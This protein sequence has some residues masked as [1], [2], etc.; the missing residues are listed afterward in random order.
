AWTAQPPW[1]PPPPA[2]G[3][4]RPDLMSGSTTTTKGFFGALF[5]F[6]FTSFVTPTIVKVV[7]ILATILIGLGYLILLVSSL[8]SGA[9]ATIV[10]LI[11]GGL[12]AL[13]YLAL[14]R[15]SLEFMYAIVRM[16]EDINRRLPKA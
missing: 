7:Y 14:V 8:R 5:D 4:G 3:G 16:S 9:A 1:G 12:G 6:G 10:T 13:V 11:A 2:G 15:I